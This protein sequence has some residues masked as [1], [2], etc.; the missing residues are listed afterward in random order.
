MNEKLY[1]VGIYIRLSRESDKYKT[2]DSLSIENQKA[3]LSKFISMMPGWI[4]TCTYID[5]G[6]SGANF[7]RRGFQDMMEDARQGIINLVLVKD[8][9][10]FGRNY[11]EAGKYLEEELPTLGCRF[12]ALSDG[13]DTETGEND[14]IPFLNAMND[15]YLRNLSDRIKSVLT[16]KAKDGQKLCGVAPYGYDRNPKN[17][18]QL[19]VDEYAAGVIRRMFETRAK[20]IGYAAIAGI[21]NQEKILPPRL[22]YLKKQ[23]REAKA[24]CTMWTERTIKLIL[25]N[26]VYAGHIA[27]FKRKTRSYRDKQT[28]QCDNSEWIYSKNTHTAI[29]DESLW[30]TV[31]EINIK[32]AQRFTDSRNPQQSLFSGMLLCADC[33]VKMAISTASSKLAD[34][35]VAKYPRHC[36]MTFRRSGRAVC[37]WHSISEK[38]LKELILSHINDMAKII[39]LDESR[40]FQALRQ[41]LIDNHSVC[42]TKR[43]KDCRELEQQLYT[44]EN[45][46]DQLY[47]DKVTCV[48]S[49]ETFSIM[50]KKI[51]ADHLEIEEKLYAMNQTVKQAEETLNDIEIWMKLIKEKSTLYEVDRDLLECLIEKIEVGERMVIDGKKVQDIRLFYK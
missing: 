39:T 6:A 9:S 8:L 21:L 30:Q 27:A 42:K 13:I 17:N 1:N 50:A 12:V 10:R 38:V 29:I 4:Q 25:R 24:A 44:T 47:E 26:E 33:Q 28:V 14:I 15:Y 3:I 46:M 48:I 31:Q 32:S 40:I 49:N 18:T 7:N 23:N 5:D 35:R 36:C 2:E 43:I 37:S 19:I 41:T 20:G 34:G 51:E 45:Q 22:Y 16:A 11:L